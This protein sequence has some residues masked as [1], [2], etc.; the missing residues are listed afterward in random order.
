[1]STLPSVTF[2]SASVPGTYVGVVRARYHFSKFTPY[3]GIG[4]DSDSLF[5]SKFSLSCDVGAYIQGNSRASVS[6]IGPIQNSPNG[7]ASLKHGAEGVV[8]STC[9]LKPTLLYR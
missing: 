7:M 5:G 6:A 2:D 9:G 3:F 4:Y 8:N 1:M